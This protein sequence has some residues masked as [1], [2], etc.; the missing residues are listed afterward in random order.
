MTSRV[1]RSV[2]AWPIDSSLGTI[3]RLPPTDPHDDD[4]EDEED[5]E[6]D[7]DKDEHEEPNRTNV[8]AE[9]SGLWLLEIT[10]YL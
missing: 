10:D 7:E 6:D 5:D 1:P 8:D 2:S 4:D 3:V 9:R